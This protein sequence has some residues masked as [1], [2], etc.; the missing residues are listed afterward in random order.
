MIWCADGA[1]GPAV[2]NRKEF[3]NST[4]KEQ[5]I[6]ENSKFDQISPEQS[7]QN[8]LFNLTFLA[9]VAVD[10]GQLVESPQ[11]LGDRVSHMR[12]G[13]KANE[14]AYEVLRQRLIGG[15]Y[16]PGAQLKEEPLAKEFGLS[17]TPVRAALKRL[18]QEGLATDDAGQGV[19]VPMWGEADIEE[20]FRLRMLL[21]PY[22]AS[23]AA[24]RGGEALV[25]EL[26]DSNAQMSTSIR[27]QDV[28]GIQKANRKFHQALLDHCG[29]P[30]LR[31]ILEQMIDI[32]IIVRSF[33]LSDRA[34]LDQ[35]LRHH[36]ELTLAAAAGDGES[37]MHAM[38]LH[39]RTSHSR[40]V[41]HREEYRNGSGRAT[42][43]PGSSPK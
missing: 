13:E 1:N 41:Q 4:K 31:T 35:S 40:F 29:S 30:R 34:E 25:R 26:S 42:V 33:Y 6:H 9:N 36:E 10:M 23:L 11:Q 27:K 22:A 39:L 43:A 12:A 24:T 38:Q 17:R 15:F 32:P 8:K 28:N 2:A 20:T 5:T 3:N 21:E 19:H 14:K 16:S 18:I 37:A 7:T